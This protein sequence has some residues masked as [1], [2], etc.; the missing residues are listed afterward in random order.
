M[1]VDPATA[2]AH[3]EVHGTSYHFCSVGCR[4]AFVAAPTDYLGPVHTKRFMD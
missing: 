4:D 1:A 3:A 2:A